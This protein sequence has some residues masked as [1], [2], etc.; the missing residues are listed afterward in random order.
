MG[1]EWKYNF[2]GHWIYGEPYILN[3]GCDKVKIYTI[4]L[5]QPLK[6][7]VIQWRIQKEFINNT[8]SKTQ[9]KKKKNRFNKI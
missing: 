4:T 1:E 6:A 9:Q 8:Q 7:L 3:V 5:K 2:E